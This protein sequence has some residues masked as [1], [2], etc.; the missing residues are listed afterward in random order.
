[1]KTEIFLSVHPNAHSSH[2]N[3]ILFCLLNTRSLV[4]EVKAII[5]IDNECWREEKWQLWVYYLLLVLRV[6]RVVL[7][8]IPADNT[9]MQK[10]KVCLLFFSILVYILS[11]LDDIVPSP[12]LKV[13][14]LFEISSL[15]LIFQVRCCWFCWM[16]F[17]H[18]FTF[19]YLYFFNKH[20][21][22]SL[23]SLLNDAK[24]EFW[25][26]SVEKEV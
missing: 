3:T 7:P 24:Y 12:S 1:M 14:W 23:N 5:E 26:F 20:N 11:T 13:H 17:Q 25:L 8:C 4:F 2:S 6:Y 10:I 22:T 15:F 9:Y 21:I 19:V 16:S 18:F